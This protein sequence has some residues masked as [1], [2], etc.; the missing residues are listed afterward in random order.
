MS[1]EKSV[2]PICGVEL[3][4]KDSRERHSLN[5]Y[6]EKAIYIIR[7]LRCIG[8]GKLHTELPDCI[9]PNKWY[10]SETI[11]AV[12]Q[13]EAED[14]RACPT[15]MKRWKSWFKRVTQHIEGLLAVIHEQPMNLLSRFSLLENQ[16]TKGPGWLK[17]V[18]EQI[19]NSGY[20]VPT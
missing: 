17:T 10:D 20:R 19:V 5:R 3:R 13:N 15:T 1:R 16:M 11:E 2:C 7:R 12:I 4:V 18:S 6:A 14:C 9:Y 8:C